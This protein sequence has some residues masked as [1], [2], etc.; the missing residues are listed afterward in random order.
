MTPCFL[1]NDAWA[2]RTELIRYSHTTVAEERDVC[3]DCWE[4]HYEAFQ[5][6]Y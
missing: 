1:C 5:H 2:D 6:E 3:D 4:A